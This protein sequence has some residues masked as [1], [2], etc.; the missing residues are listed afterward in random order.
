MTVALSGA[1]WCAVAV[2]L[3]FTARR[4]VFLAASLFPGRAYGDEA[5]PTVA[6]LV[7]A[8]NEAACIRA[9]LDAIASLDYP[10]G[11]LTVVLIDDGSTDSTG[12]QLRG[13][14]EG[15]PRVLLL[16]LPSPAGKFPALN[17]AVALAP[18]VE[19]IAVCDADLRPHRD[20]LRAL[21]APFADG[22]VGSTAGLI[23]PRNAER[24]PV[25]RYAAVESWVHQLITSAAKD[26]LGLG[27]PT[28]GASAYRLAALQEVGMFLGAGPGGD[29]RTSAA[30]T[31]AGWRAC[32]VRDAVVDNDVVDRW[33]D[34]WHQ[35]VRWARNVFSTARPGSSMRMRPTLLTRA[36]ALATAA[37]YADRI[38]LVI[39]VALT[40]AG[41]LPLFPLTTYFV[42]V[43]AEVAVAVARAGRASRLPVYLLTTACFFVVD[44]AASFAAAALELTHRPRRWRQ[45]RHDLPESP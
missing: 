40:A 21:V 33:D 43:V 36:E 32:F 13:W 41:L 18:D 25:A 4:A 31:R 30:L 17:R 45:I 11:R 9:T 29:V 8:R 3:L 16:H 23:S 24:G 15:R 28:L 1:A 6:L 19:V 26:R 39:V 44:V 35:H 10:A 42:I 34:Y 20:W 37:G 12:E 2:L 5:L 14:A 22:R 27:P 38:V 7:P